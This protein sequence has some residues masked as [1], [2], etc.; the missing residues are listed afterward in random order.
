MRYSLTKTTSTLMLSA[1]LLL[2]CGGDNG[3]GTPIGDSSGHQF[4]LSDVGSRGMS[5]NGEATLLESG[6]D[7]PEVRMELSRR[8]FSISTSPRDMTEF[9]NPSLEFR[10]SPVGMALHIRGLVEE[11]EPGRVTVAI[12][13]VRPDFG[14]LGTSVDEE[15]R[16]N[17]AAH[18]ISIPEANQDNPIMVTLSISA[19]D[20]DNRE[21]SVTSDSPLIGS[22][23][24]RDGERSAF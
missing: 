4:E 6:L 2:G 20:E 8:V 3:A 16:E 9:N 10:G 19:V 11:D 1:A 13:S 14:S 24:M 17:V 18:G 15:M 7:F 21:I 23:V 12:E 5:W 22:I